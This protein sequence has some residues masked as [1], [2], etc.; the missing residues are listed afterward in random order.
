[1]GDSTEISWTDS[2]FNPWIGCTNISPGCDHCYAEL[3]AARYGWAR[4]GKHPRKRT[5]PGNW[6]K[7]ILWN[8]DA[9]AFARAHG[10]RRRRVFCASLS[11]WLDNK[12][13]ASWRTDLCRLIEQTPALDWL[14]LTKRPENFRKLVPPTW[15]DGLPS[16]VWFG[17]TAEDAE[18]YRRRWTIAAAVPARVH[19]VSYEP[20]IGPL[21]RLH[22]SAGAPVPDWIIV[23]GESGPRA[24]VM[25]PQWARDVRDQ[26]VALGIAFFLKQWGTYRSNPAGEAAMRADPPTNGKGGALLDRRL[27]REFPDRRDPISH[28]T[29]EATWIGAA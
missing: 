11:D 4:W 24:R 17:F 10:G 27:W 9:L 18:H 1:M 19:F 21:G 29:R 26:C 16:N 14:L 5:S 3:M 23:G 7:P 6:R 15:R 8:A 28:E 12:A 2:T 25:N 20:A 13:P 22:L